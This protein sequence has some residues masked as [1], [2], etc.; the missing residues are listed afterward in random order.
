[1]ATCGSAC[2]SFERGPDPA[3]G[4]KGSNFAHY[5][6]IDDLIEQG[7]LERDRHQRVKLYQEAQHRIMRDAVLPASLRRPVPAAA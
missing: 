3:T 4:N 1:M 2:S 5:K 6:G 7:R